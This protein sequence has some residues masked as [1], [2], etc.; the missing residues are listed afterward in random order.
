MKR[1]SHLVLALV[2]FFLLAIGGIVLFPDVSREETARGSMKDIILAAHN[3]YRAELNLPALEWS[4]KLASHAQEWA[5]HL[6][7]RGGRS[8]VHSSNSSRPGEGENLWMGTAGYY[9]YAQMVDSWGAEKRYFR[10][11]TFPRVSTSGNWF[12]VGH[13]TQIIWKNTQ[14][15]GCALATAGGNDVLVCRYSPPGNYIGQPVY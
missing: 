9:S 1:L 14:Q 7:R 5:D 3:R 8:L 2:A 10:K 6:A 11:G 4:D 15:V 12:D 13:Y